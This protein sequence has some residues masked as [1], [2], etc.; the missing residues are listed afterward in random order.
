M[1]TSIQPRIDPQK[2]WPILPF[3]FD[4]GVSTESDALVSVSA[5]GVNLNTIWEQV[6]AAIKAWNAERSAL[7]SLLTFNTTNSADAILRRQVLNLSRLQPNTAN[8]K[9]YALQRLICWPDIR[10]RIMTLLPAGHGSSYAAPP[11]SR[12]WLRPTLRLRLTT[13]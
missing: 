8:R 12:F 1:S 10:L 4:R 2:L 6:A 5:D 11:K 13:N 3:G 9:H 7:T